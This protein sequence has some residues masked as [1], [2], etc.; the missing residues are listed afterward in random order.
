MASKP[1]KIALIATI[2]KLVAVSSM[3][4]HRKPF[5]LILSDH[6]PTGAANA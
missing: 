6:R 2:C 3:A 4:T 5:V 1:G